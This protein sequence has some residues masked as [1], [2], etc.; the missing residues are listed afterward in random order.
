MVLSQMF[1]TGGFAV[2]INSAHTLTSASFGQLPSFTVLG[3]A[4]GPRL[5]DKIIRYIARSGKSPNFASVFKK[6]WQGEAAW[7]KGCVIQVHNKSVEILRTR[8]I[9]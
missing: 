5:P 4:G 8:E 6:L 9:T 2:K 1:T 3:S 7:S